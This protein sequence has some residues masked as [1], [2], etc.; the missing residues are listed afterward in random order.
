MS[1]PVGARRAAA[2]C[3]RTRV[4]TELQS[5][6]LFEDRFGRPGKGND[7]GKDEGPVGVSVVGPI[8]EKGIGDRL[9]KSAQRVVGFAIRGFA[10][11]K[12]EGDRPPLGRRAF[13]NWS[14]MSKPGIPI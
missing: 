12:V 10:E 7:K 2:P 8:G 6:Y 9:R 5:H 4:F 13:D 1:T 3:Q 14:G 11:C